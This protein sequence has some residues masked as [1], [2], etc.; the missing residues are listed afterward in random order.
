[1]FICL[2]WVRKFHTYIY[3]R[4]ITVHNDHKPLEMILKKPIHAAPPSLQRMLLHLQKYDDTIGY[5]PGKEMV[6]A[7]CLSHFPQRKENLPIQLHQ[8]IQNI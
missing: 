7:D 1:M 2:L 8:N 6:L 3:G 4:H 5:K